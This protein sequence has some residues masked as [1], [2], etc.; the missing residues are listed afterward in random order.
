MPSLK[1]IKIIGL[2]ATAVGVIASLAN[3]WSRDVQ[4]DE[5]MDRKLDEKLD[6]RFAQIQEA[7]IEEE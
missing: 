3:D 7:K 5:K 6:E 2:V 4:A 1:V